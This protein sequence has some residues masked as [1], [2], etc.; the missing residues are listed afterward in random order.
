MGNLLKRTQ[1][2][3]LSFAWDPDHRGWML[4]PL[5]DALPKPQQGND[6]FLHLGTGAPGTAGDIGERLVPREAVR[7]PSNAGK[8]N[9][10]SDCRR[11]RRVAY[12]FRVWNGL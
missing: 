5:H 3:D 9:C 11:G 6:R 1:Y 2:W 8:G 10:P 12:F 4:S 7:Y